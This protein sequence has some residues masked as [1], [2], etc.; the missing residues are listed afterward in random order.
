MEIHQAKPDDAPEILALQ[1]LAYH[2][3]ALIYN[4]F[5]IPPLKQTMEELAAQ[6]Y[7]HTILKVV[8]NDRIIAS[9]RAIRR[10]NT[11]HIGRLI[12][13]PDFQN[14]GIGTTLLKEIEN[15]CPAPRYEL[16]TGAKS[17]K[18]LHIYKKHGYK[19]FRSQKQTENLT[20]VFLYK[21]TNPH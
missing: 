4:N 19:K 7:D 18:N 11:C 13:H 10:E 17:K 20:I 16:F 21:T 9:V 12:V 3:Q 5:E 6:F 8:K 15:R 14:Q 1:K 2:G